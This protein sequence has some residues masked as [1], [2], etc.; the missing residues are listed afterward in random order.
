MRVK[1]LKSSKIKIAK[2]N[3]SCCGAIAPGAIPQYFA[4][5]PNPVLPIANY[6]NEI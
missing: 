5:D 1:K 3:V 6:D 2:I 4:P